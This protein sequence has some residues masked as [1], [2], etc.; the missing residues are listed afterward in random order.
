MKK[1]LSA[2]LLGL[3]LSIQL[4]APH[5]ALAQDWWNPSF[6][7]FRD[8][9]TQAPAEEIFGERYTMAQVSWIINSFIYILSGVVGQCMESSADV[10]KFVS[11]IESKQASTNGGPILALAGGIDSLHNT[12][13]ASGINYV[14]QK[15]DNLNII[16]EAYAQQQGYGFSNAL[17][18]IQ[19]L[20]VISRNA[21]YA[22]L[23][24]VVIAMAFMIM[25]RAKVSPQASITIQS[26]IPRIFIAAVA[27]TFSY[28]IAGFL[29]DLAFVIQALVS[30]IVAGSVVDPAL[31][32][33]AIT[34]FT[35][36][37]D[38]V[39]ATVA[40]GIAFILQ[41]FSAIGGILGG[42]GGLVGMALNGGG[43]LGE[44]ILNTVA[45]LPDIIIGLIVLVLLLIGLMR[46]FWLL[47]LTYGKTIFI[48][49]CAP[50][51]ILL[52]AA[53]PSGSIFGWVKSLV[54]QLAVFV[55][56]GI[57]VL[58]AHILFWGF[59]E[60]SGTINL[61]GIYNALNL[62][63][64]GIK[65][66]LAGGASGTLPSGFNFGNNMHAIGFFVSLAIILSIP[67]IANS[68]RDFIATGKAT[69]GF[70]IGEA[71]APISGPMGFVQN[72]T[73]GAASKG[74]GGVASA[75]FGARFP[76]V[77]AA[78]KPRVPGTG[79]GGTPPGV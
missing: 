6:P 63:P 12:R 7:A 52:G 49:I 20:W 21:T 65:S 39:G 43:W 11:C 75:H 10:A 34:V 24:L 56:I 38:G 71:L 60:S 45:F 62:N 41:S 35:T 69:F 28:A 2:I 1:R 40:Y 64:F 22:L 36:M 23:V 47:I 9:V 68:V 37:N 5:A 18:P 33:N 55:S 61:D 73:V 51:A 8:K 44:G 4:I 77:I 57:I 27:I 31:N 30:A 54:A 53:M 19:K 78:L 32:K 3:L 67:K 29:V 76:G 50:F 48:V 46:V 70:G 72:A 16:P 14:A 66:G 42:G 59:R 17:A 15:L 26:A 58:M 74:F 25:F 13:P 79:G